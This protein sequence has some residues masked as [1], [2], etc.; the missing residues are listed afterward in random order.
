M[1]SSVKSQI[2]TRSTDEDAARIAGEQAWAQYEAALDR[3]QRVNT[4][5][6]WHVVPSLVL[7]G[8][9]ERGDTQIIDSLVKGHRAHGRAL[10]LWALKHA[11]MSD[12][13]VQSRLFA[14]VH[15]SRPCKSGS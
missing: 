2:V 6:Y 8:V 9:H 4:A 5:I 12:L 11:D 1:P 15:G 14:A 13:G 7:T 3:W 10:V